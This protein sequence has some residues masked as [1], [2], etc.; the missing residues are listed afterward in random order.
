MSYCVSLS[1]KKPDISIKHTNRPQFSQIF[2]DD[3]V[4]AGGCNGFVQVCSRRMVYGD[5][6]TETRA[7]A[8]NKLL[9]NYRNN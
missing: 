3:R 4:V 2:S 1:R 9:D 7:P 8:L 5:A 6:I